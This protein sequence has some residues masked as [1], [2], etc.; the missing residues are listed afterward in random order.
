MKNNI[1]LQF[2]SHAEVVYISG[3][4]GFVKKNETVHEL[5]FVL[6]DESKRCILSFC[7]C[8]H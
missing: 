5:A 7:S 4:P 2:L 3:T 8:D 1:G 6:Y